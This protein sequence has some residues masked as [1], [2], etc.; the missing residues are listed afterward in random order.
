MSEET[1]ARFDEEGDFDPVGVFVEY[2]DHE[3]AMNELREMNKRV[4]DVLYEDRRLHMEEV[5]RLKDEIAA[6]KAVKP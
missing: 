1:I 5:C 3:R 6:L 2:E 4:W